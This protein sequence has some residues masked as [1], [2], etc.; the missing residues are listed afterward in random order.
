MINRIPPPPNNSVTDGA[1][2]FVLGFLVSVA[3]WW[4]LATQMDYPW[5]GLMVGA[6]MITLG[7]WIMDYGR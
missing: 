5:P 3:G 2:R 4:Y 7:R 6:V 1:A